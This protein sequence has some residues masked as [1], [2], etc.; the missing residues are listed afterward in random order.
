MFARLIVQEG[1]FPLKQ[2]CGQKYSTD[3]DGG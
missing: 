2:A 3:E 1:V